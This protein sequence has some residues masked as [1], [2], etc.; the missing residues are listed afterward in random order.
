MGH[1]SFLSFRKLTEIVNLQLSYFSFYL[2]GH[3]SEYRSQSTFWSHFYSTSAFGMVWNPF[4]VKP[5]SSKCLSYRISQTRYLIK[6]KR[7]ENNR[8]IYLPTRRR[9]APRPWLWVALA[10][11]ECITCV[12]IFQLQCIWLENCHPPTRIC[13]KVSIKKLCNFCELP[14]FSQIQVSSGA[15]T[16][17]R[18]QA[19]LS[20]V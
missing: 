17:P 12:H 7:L 20:K 14:T 18:G 16:N 9:S 13:Y 8:I 15:M 4:L 6:D 10:R 2:R 5:F 1:K 19:N 11:A 3:L